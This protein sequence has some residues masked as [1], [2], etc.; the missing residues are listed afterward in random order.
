MKNYTYPADGTFAAAPTGDVSGHELY[1]IALAE[2]ARGTGDYQREGARIRIR[3]ITIRAFFKLNTSHKGA[4]AAGTQE[5]QSPYDKFMVCLVRLGRNQTSSL[6]DNAEIGNMPTTGEWQYGWKMLRYPCLSLDEGTDYILHPA[7][8][9]RVAPSAD[10]ADTFYAN[11]LDP[12]MRTPYSIV[13]YKNRRGRLHKAQ[14]W[15]TIPYSS[16]GYYQH[17]V[18]TDP[19]PVDYNLLMNNIHRRMFCFDIPCN[20][21]QE[22][23]GDTGREKFN[24][25]L[26]LTYGRVY[27]PYDLSNLPST[28]V[29]LSDDEAIGYDVDQPCTMYYQYRIQFTDD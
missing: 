23:F 22:Y 10:A 6:E 2:I 24:N 25:G 7:W 12:P 8:N 26:F 13:R 15:I 9:K 3:R 28:E 17:V 20:I 5:P 29:G 4:L 14:K 21:P 18:S 1:R 19:D 27:Q 16:D 11:G